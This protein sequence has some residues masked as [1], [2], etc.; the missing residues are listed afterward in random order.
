MGKLKYIFLF[1]TSLTV[2]VSC[3]K[4]TQ[5]TGPAGAQGS[6][7]VPGAN[8]YGA[9][10]PELLYPND[11]SLTATPNLY[12]WTTVYGS[13]NPN[14]SMH[15][16]L[17]VYATKPS[18]PKEDYRLPW[19]GVWTYTTPATDV[20]YSSMQGDVIQIWYYNSGGTWPASNDST[21]EFQWTI[22][23]VNQ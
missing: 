10:E 17:T 3:S 20:L 14:P 13:Y 23:P 11:F 4:N 15:Y 8:V 19:S 16:Q 21:I 7:G 5:I 18:V 9:S 1:V 22:I 6:T 12:L 2:F